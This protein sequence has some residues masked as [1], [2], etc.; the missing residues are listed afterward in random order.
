MPR[1]ALNKDS[2]TRPRRTF[3]LLT[4]DSQH[5]TSIENREKPMRTNKRGRAL[6]NPLTTKTNLAAVVLGSLL[7]TP[8]T[9]AA[10]CAIAQAE[11]ATRLAGGA[12]NHCPAASAG[13]D[14]PVLVNQS[15]TLD[16]T[17]SSDVDGDPLSF[18]WSVVQAP[19]GSAVE[20]AAPTAMRTSFVPDQIGDYIFHLTVTDAKGAVMTDKVRYSTANVAPVANAG[21]DRNARVGEWVSLDALR[22][23]DM[24][25]DVLE[26][27]WRL[28][29][30]PAASASSVASRRAGADLYIDSPGDYVAELVVSD[31]VAG[32][33]ADS[34]RISTLNSIPTANAGKN[35]RYAPGSTVALSGAAS[36]DLDGD[37]LAYS[38]SLLAAPKGSE[39]VLDDGAHSDPTIYLDEAGMYLF[40]LVVDDGELASP[41]DTVVIE[42]VA[43]RLENVDPKDYRHMVSRGGGDDT[44]GDGV[45]DLD[46]NCVVVAN[47]AQRDTDGDGLGNFCDADL[48]N[49]GI[50]NAHRS[51]YLQGRLLHRRCGRRL[52]RRRHRQRDRSRHSQERLLPATGP[53]RPDHLGLAGR[54]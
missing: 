35:H 47:P 4:S 27:T 3:L 26:Y 31:G 44:D 48:N 53:G 9:H 12:M 54:R 43:D 52:Q 37:A 11:L 23:Y 42:L 13:Q 29:D 17:L 8:V 40:Q 39:A 20:I 18:A 6:R 25:D 33:V 49:D 38:W 24:N 7:L 28:I 16:A 19:E 1:R 15:A 34:V 41:A 14:M 21:D 10:D 5:S 30:A 51:G 36:A 50:V 32:S 22:S 45:L 2:N 46:D